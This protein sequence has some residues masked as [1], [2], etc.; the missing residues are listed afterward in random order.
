MVHIEELTVCMCHFIIVLSSYPISCFLA[1]F[2][3]SHQQKNEKF[4]RNFHAR[5]PMYSHLEFTLYYKGNYFK[6]F[7]IN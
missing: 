7:N 2:S 4:E 5:P 6:T 1:K 3:M